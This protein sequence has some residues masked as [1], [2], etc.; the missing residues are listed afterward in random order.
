MMYL[1]RIAEVTLGTFLSLTTRPTETGV[2]LRVLES[3]GD[4]ER[5]TQTVKS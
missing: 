4:L 2:H 3:E 1:L 5:K